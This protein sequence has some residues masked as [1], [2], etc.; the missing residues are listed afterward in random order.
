MSA[1]PPAPGRLAQPLRGLGGHT[2]L[3][4]YNMPVMRIEQHFSTSVYCTRGYVFTS[5]LQDLFHKQLINL[6]GVNTHHISV[7]IQ[8]HAQD[9]LPHVNWQHELGLNNYFLSLAAETI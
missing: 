4:S 3:V 7:T 5:S 2:E 6:D 9:L 8:G 1:A